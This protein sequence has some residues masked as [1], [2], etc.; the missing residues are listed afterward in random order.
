MSAEKIRD[1]AHVSKVVGGIAALL[2]TFGALPLN[3]LVVG[4]ILLVLAAYITI[5]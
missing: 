5:R 2:L 1:G 4:L 3:A